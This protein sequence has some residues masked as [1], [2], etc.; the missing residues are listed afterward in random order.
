M[1]IEY[2]MVCLECREELPVGKLLVETLPNGD[3]RRT[4]GGT[5][6]SLTNSTRY[7]LWG[8]ELRKAVEGFLILHIGHE[9]AFLSE[10][11]LDGAKFDVRSVEDDEIEKRLIE[12]SNRDQEVA[13]DLFAVL[14]PSLARR[15][16]ELRNGT[17]SH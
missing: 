12:L 15:M 9:L 17:E 7:R 6:T 14:S 10:H 1:G 16:K 5:G 4:F 2:S 8:D 11:A 13:V 3:C